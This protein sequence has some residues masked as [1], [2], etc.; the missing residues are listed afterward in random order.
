VK[1]NQKGSRITCATLKPATETETET[2]L[3]SC[4][5]EALTPGPL[6]ADRGYWGLN[7]LP[8]PA[9]HHRREDPAAR[10]RTSALNLAMIRRRR[11]CG[12]RVDRKGANQRKATMSGFYDAMAAKQGREASSSH[13]PP[14]HHGCPVRKSA[15]G[16]GK[17]SQPALDP[18]RNLA[19]APPRTL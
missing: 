14:I 8:S 16:Q 15:I 18:T 5:R 4:P 17:H 10:H 2:L 12:R 11:Q 7:R 19:E 3:T 9:R 13:P 1:G 6:A